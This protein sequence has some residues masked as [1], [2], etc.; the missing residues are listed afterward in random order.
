MHEEGYSGPHSWD[1]STWPVPAAPDCRRPS[2]AAP[3]VR[4]SRPGPPSGPRALSAVKQA[5]P[6]AGPAGSR[7]AA[8]NRSRD[9]APTAGPAPAES[10]LK[11]SSVQSRR[12]T[13]PRGPIAVARFDS[14]GRGLV[15]PEQLLRL[16]IGHVFA[17]RP[18]K[19]TQQCGRDQGPKAGRGRS[20]KPAGK[21]GGR[22]NLPGAWVLPESED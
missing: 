1:P 11:R 7:P 9:P 18:G 10:A 14:W 15:Q 6:S 12:A 17:A 8:S 22:D 4:S 16:S 20:L 3:S 13:Q 19:S 2:L 21:D 5:R